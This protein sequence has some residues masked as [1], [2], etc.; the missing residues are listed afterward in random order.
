MTNAVIAAY[1]KCGS[2]RKTAKHLGVSRRRVTKLLDAASF[3]RRK[4]RNKAA[5]TKCFTCEFARAD[6]CLFMAAVA[7]KAETALRAMGA[8]YESRIC[9]SRDQRSNERDILLLTV[10]KCP[11]YMGA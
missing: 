11:K 10:L 1:Q 2:V 7:N 3:S 4:I 9:V 8:K 6:K 5:D